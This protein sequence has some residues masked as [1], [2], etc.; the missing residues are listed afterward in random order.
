MSRED[1]AEHIL[2]GAIAFFA[3]RGFG[4]QTRELTERLGI[5][6]ALLFKYYPNKET[7]IDAIYDVMFLQRWKPEWRS[8]LVDRKVALLSRL[9]VFYL[10]YS[11]LLHDRDWARI[12]LY[13]GLAGAPIARRFGDMVIERVYR[14]VIGE[15]RHEFGAVPFSKL[16]PT[17]AELELMWSLHGSIFYIAIR[18][19]VY[20]SPVP[21]DV[22]ATI[23]RLVSDHYESARN[24]V[25][26]GPAALSSSSRSV[27]RRNGSSP[28]SKGPQNIT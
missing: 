1:R 13:S 11:Q 25:G 10:D 19:W 14:P 15:L 26:K 7:L 18:K 5:S 24:I 12:Y 21:T 28:R 22:E 8:V 23:R 9:Q 4:G 6:N 16:A 20:H 2:Q 27:S 3:E 17:E